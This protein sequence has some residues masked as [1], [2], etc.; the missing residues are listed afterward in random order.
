MGA[1]K[2]SLVYG[3]SALPQ[4]RSA[5]ACLEQVCGQA[6]VSVNAEQL[7]DSL[8]AQLPTIVDAET[9]RGPAQGLLSALQFNPTTAWLVLAVDM[10]RVSVPLLS[11]LIAQRDPSRIATVHCHADGTIEPLCAIWEPHALEAIVRELESGRGSLRALANE[12]H[13]AVARLPEPERLRNANTPAERCEIQQQLT[14]AG[15]KSSEG[16]R[17]GA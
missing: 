13:A 11:N 2:G 10:P 9:D 15:A 16:G 7:E 12:Q 5:L 6:W 14:D 17:S 3:D 8:Y 4:V 1:D